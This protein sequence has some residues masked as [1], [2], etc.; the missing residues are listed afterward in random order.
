MVGMLFPKQGHSASQSHYC[1]A[2]RSRRKTM[3]VWGGPCHSF[4]LSGICP[5]DCL[6]NG[7]CVTQHGQLC[8]EGF[9]SLRCA[10]GM[11]ELTPPLLL[12]AGEE[13][14]YFTVSN[15]LQ[16][17]SGLLFRQWEWDAQTHRGERRRTWTN[18]STATEKGEE[19]FPCRYWDSGADLAVV[20]SSWFCASAQEVFYDLSFFPQKPAINGLPPTPKVLVRN[21]VCSGN[22]GNLLSLVWKVYAGKRHQLI[23]GDFLHLTAS[24]FSTAG[25]TIFVSIV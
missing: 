3:N 20:S 14:F 7:K 9:S 5:R 13:I 10:Y 15:Q 21:P 2:C 22:Y 25:S 11:S 17:M 12:S 23:W 4:I 1:V 16:T 19:R 18:P 24:Y 8:W 6:D